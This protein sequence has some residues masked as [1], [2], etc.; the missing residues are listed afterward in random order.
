MENAPFY[1][2]YLAMAEFMQTFSISAAFK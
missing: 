2:E 1:A